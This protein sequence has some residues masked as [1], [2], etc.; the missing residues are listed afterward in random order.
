MVDRDCK[1]IQQDLGESCKNLLMKI[2][3]S[4]V[5]MRKHLFKFVQMYSFLVSGL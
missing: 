4:T 3:D 5:L 1:S 2:K